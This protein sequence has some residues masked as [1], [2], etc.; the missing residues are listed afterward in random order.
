MKRLIAMGTSGERRVAAT[1]R[2]Q[3]EQ[4]LVDVARGVS[5]DDFEQIV[6]G[7]VFTP[8]DGPMYYE[9]LDKA[10]GRSSFAYIDT[11]PDGVPDPWLPPPLPLTR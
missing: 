11:V 7:D 6:F 1:F 3:G 5:K 9:A 8:A 4:V 10:F 2:L